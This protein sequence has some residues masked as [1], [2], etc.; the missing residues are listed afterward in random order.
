[1]SVFKYTF[2]KMEDDVRPKKRVQNS[3]MD[4]HV[5]VKNKRS[6]GESYIDRGGN[7]IPAKVFHNGD[8]ICRKE[9][10]TL[11]VTMNERRRTNWELRQAKRTS[12]CM[13]WSITLMLLD[14]VRAWKKDLLL[15]SILFI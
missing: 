13:G 1:M 15:L 7:L 8:C 14:I 5:S 3:G 12:V 2:V 9:K 4:T 6:S 11:R 10:C